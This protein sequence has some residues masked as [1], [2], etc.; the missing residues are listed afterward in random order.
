MIKNGFKHLLK[1]TLIFSA[2]GGAYYGL[3]ILF[4]GYSNWTM[5]ICAGIIG[6]LASLLNNFFTF[7][8]LLQY[9]LGISAVIA[10]ACEGITG[11][12]ILHFNNGVNPVWDYSNLWGS[13]CKY[14]CN[15]WFSLLWGLLSFI[16]ILIGDS[17]E[18]YLFDNADERP[19]YCINTHGIWFWLP[20]KTW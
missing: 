2:C 8:M 20:R 14:Q 6:L 3:E 10:T 17:I 9:Q 1:N 11:L 16:A 19:Y 12:L 7:D 13:F 18:Y 5:F 4:R 15:I